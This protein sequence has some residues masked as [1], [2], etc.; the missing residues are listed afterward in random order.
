MCSVLREMMKPRLVLCFDIARIGNGCKYTPL[1]RL[2]MTKIWYCGDYRRPIDS[3]FRRS[4]RELA[5]GA[6][7]PG[8]SVPLVV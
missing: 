5:L 1:S 4:N 8:K 6:K 3:I 7:V 2:A